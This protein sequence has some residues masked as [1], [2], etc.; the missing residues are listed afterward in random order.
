MRKLKCRMLNNRLPEVTHK[1][2][3]QQG[4]A[5]GKRVA[6]VSFNS[7]VPWSTCHFYANETRQYGTSSGVTTVVEA[8]NSMYSNRKI[9][10]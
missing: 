5:T 10:E 1:H 4:L 2:I 9:V 7:Y 8:L 3:V 6:E